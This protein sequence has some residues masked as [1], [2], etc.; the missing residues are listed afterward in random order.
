[1]RRSPRAGRLSSAK[2]SRA[3]LGSTPGGVGVGVDHPAV[4][5]EITRSAVFEPDGGD[6]YARRVKVMDTDGA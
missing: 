1:M 4:I 6:W 2:G 5:G 3:W